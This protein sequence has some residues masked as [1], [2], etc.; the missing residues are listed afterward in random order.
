[1][2]TPPEFD[3]PTASLRKSAPNDSAAGCDFRKVSRQIAVRRVGGDVGV[4][5]EREVT[6]TSDP[7]RV[8]FCKSGNPAPNPSFWCG[9]MPQ[10]NRKTTGRDNLIRPPREC[11]EE[12]ILNRIQ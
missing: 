4:E 11:G 6:I 7:R 1:M 12:V 8:A 3:V 5:G 10:Y 9:E 2:A